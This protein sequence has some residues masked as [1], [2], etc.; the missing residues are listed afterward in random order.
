MKRSM[1]WRLMT[2][3]GMFFAA[4]MAGVN[5]AYLMPDQPYEVSWWKAAGLTACFLICLVGYREPDKRL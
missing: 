2:L 1:I 4:F 5:V 3:S